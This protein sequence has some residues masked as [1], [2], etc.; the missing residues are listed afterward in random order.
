MEGPDRDPEMPMGD[1]GKGPPETQTSPQ[2]KVLLRDGEGWREC[3]PWDGGPTR[4][5]GHGA[6]G[7]RP[8]REAQM[9]CRCLH[10]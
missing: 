2:I 3:E 7:G 9:R 10:T 6:A 5:A 8:G 4:N 1:Q